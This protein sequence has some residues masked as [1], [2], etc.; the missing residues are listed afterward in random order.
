MGNGGTQFVIFDAFGRADDI[1]WQ[2]N[3]PRGVTLGRRRRTQG[4]DRSH[5]KAQRLDLDANSTQLS[6]NIKG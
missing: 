4:F 2:R 5:T 3:G 6:Q 1:A